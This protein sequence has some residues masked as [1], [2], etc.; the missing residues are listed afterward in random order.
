MRCFKCANE[1]VELPEGDPARESNRVRYAPAYVLDVVG[2]GPGGGGPCRAAVV[3]WTCWNEIEPDMWDAGEY[4]DA[5]SPAVLFEKLP[6]LDHDA[7][8]CWDIETY[9]NVP[10]PLSKE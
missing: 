6:A 5:R 7:E 8:T 9:S 2:G 4:W 10:V 3:C 1:I